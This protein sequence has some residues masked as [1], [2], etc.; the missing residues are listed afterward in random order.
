MLTFVTYEKSFDTIDQHIKVLADCR[1]EHRYTVLIKH[2]YENTSASVRF[3]DNV[4]CFGRGVH[5]GEA[6]TTQLFNIFLQ[7]T[8]KRLNWDDF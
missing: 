7:Y 6:I 3:H 5:R 2:I 8:C 4:N 1:I